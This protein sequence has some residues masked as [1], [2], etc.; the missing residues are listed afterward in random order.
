MRSVDSALFVQALG[1]FFAIMNP[2]IALPMFLALTSG[3]D[4]AR[5]RRTGLRV[6]VYSAVMSIVVMASGS[7]ILG[8]F[9]IS[10]SHFRVAGGIVLMTIGL[11]M[12]NGGSSAHEGT[13][14]EK[15]RM[16]TR[17]MASAGGEAGVTATGPA[18]GPAHDAHPDAAADISFYPLTFPMI[19]GPGSIASIVIFTGQADGVPGIVAVILA[20]AAV[21]AVLFVVLWFAPFIGRR[22]SE[23]LRMIM[24][25]LMGMI[26]A[27]I[28]VAMVIAGL[29][30]L[31]PIL[32]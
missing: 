26:V 6:V 14:T 4:H 2:F 1:A 27:A 25:R 24:T 17:A 3:Y 21:L 9:G 10:V 23:T 15:A 30:E 7:A 20:L 32:R 16:R 28:A 19:L 11:G 22:M 13:A 5:Q 29:Q 8:F 31:I 12:L 18:A